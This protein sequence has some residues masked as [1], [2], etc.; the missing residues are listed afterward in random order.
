MGLSCIADKGCLQYRYASA[1]DGRLETMYKTNSEDE[2]RQAYV[3]YK[4]SNLAR[5]Q[6]T[7]SRALKNLAAE[8]G[9]F[10]EKCNRK[11]SQSMSPQSMLRVKPEST[12][13]QAKGSEIRQKVLCEAQENGEQAMR[14]KQEQLSRTVDF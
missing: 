14:V 12:T 8:R 9:K 10:T 1:G 4:S 5:G 6:I 3:M 11:I 13:E 7:L 2:S